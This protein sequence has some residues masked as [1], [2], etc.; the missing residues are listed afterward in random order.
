MCKER[1]WRYRCDCQS[2]TIQPC[3]HHCF[4]NAHPETSLRSMPRD[5]GRPPCAYASPM[6]M[7]VSS[8]WRSPT[9]C[10]PPKAYM[11]AAGV[12]SRGS[13]QWTGMTGPYERMLPSL[14]QG[15]ES[16]KP[17]PDKLSIT[18]ILPARGSRWRQI[19][20]AWRQ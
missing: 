7:N 11:V 18:E 6:S 15:L 4:E 8:G 5:Q 12:C 2:T 10:L 17:G 13:Y 9:E 14:E 16:G 19:L 20:M 3:R 1:K